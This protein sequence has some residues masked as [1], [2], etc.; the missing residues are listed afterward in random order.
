[1]MEFD[2]QVVTVRANDASVI[3]ALRRGFVLHD[4]PGVSAGGITVRT[5]VTPLPDGTHSIKC[6]YMVPAGKTPLGTEMQ[7]P[8]DLGYLTQRG[9]DSLR[10]HQHAGCQVTLELYATK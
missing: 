9:F 10:Q 6:F 5:V 4:A 3:D 2:S 8:H 1:M 7:A